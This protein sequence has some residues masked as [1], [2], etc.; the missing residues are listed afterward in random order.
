MKTAH[1]STVTASLAGKY[2]LSFREAKRVYDAMRA[3][4]GRAT[5]LRMVQRAPER[6]PKRWKPEPV[7]PPPRPK[8]KP[9]PKPEP[10]PRPKPRKAP[11][12]A[13]PAGKRNS[14]QKLAKPPAPAPAPAERARPKRRKAGDAPEPRPEGKAT[15]ERR[16]H[17]YAK[18]TAARYHKPG[19]KL[20]PG[21][22][23]AP[24]LPPKSEPRTV[25]QD[26]VAQNRFER[27]LVER[28]LPVELARNTSGKDVVGLWRDDKTQT[29]IADALK[30]AY[31]Q[32][33][34]EGRI[35]A[36]TKERLQGILE[37]AFGD[38]WMNVM[39][40]IVR[41]LYR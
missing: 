28:G 10:K 37:K 35:K 4:A 19:D 9:E 1:W 26:Q 34:R 6:I 31:G 15:S 40:Q 5:S 16:K 13:P 32:I 29:Q 20:A 22:T 30:T 8:A 3:E 21:I 38:K 27:K 17:R 41:N 18:E 25:R 2:N 24:A 11:P 33:K 39:G 23:A 36:S 7:K 14:K 12:P